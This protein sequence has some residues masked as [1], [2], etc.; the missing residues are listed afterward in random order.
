MVNSLRGLFVLRL[1][2]TR[3]SSCLLK[4]IGNIV[5]TRHGPMNSYDF[6]FTPVLGII[7][8]LRIPVGNRYCTSVF[9]FAGRVTLS[10]YSIRI[11]NIFS[12]DCSFC[13]N[14]NESLSKFQGNSLLKGARL[15]FLSC[16]V[17]IQG[18]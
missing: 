15:Q 6:T 7:V 2:C 13:R 12:I 4:I 10:R 9:H 11:H 5:Q 3:K 1:E 16:N 17:S 14:E 18:L 8:F